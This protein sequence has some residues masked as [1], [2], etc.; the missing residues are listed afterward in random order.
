MRVRGVNG[1]LGGADHGL[2]SDA[3]VAERCD[4]EAGGRTD[5]E[6]APS[7]AT[8]WG[9]QNLEFVSLAI[10]QR[11]P[12]GCTVAGVG[13]QR[14]D[15]VM[16]AEYLFGEP[17]TLVHYLIDHLVTHYNLDEPEALVRA[18]RAAGS[19]VDQLTDSS[20]RALAVGHLAERVGRSE[21]MIATALESYSRTAERH[22]ER[23]VTRSLR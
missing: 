23:S 7:V 3:G 11:C 15:G 4:A 19:L 20:S 10:G 17:L 22:R 12:G 21:E 13:V 9:C 18:L 8:D 2:G 1:C 16:P 6:D 5:L 14:D